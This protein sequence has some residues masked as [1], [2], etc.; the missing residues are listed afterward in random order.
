[1]QRSELGEIGR[2]FEVLGALDE[3]AQAFRA[4]A[5][6]ASLARVLG[7]AGDVDGLEEALSGQQ[8]AERAQRAIEE[9]R[10]AAHHAV[11]TGQRE[12][13]LA[14]LTAVLRTGPNAEL[15]RLRAAIEEAR[16]AR[17]GTR[18]IDARGIARTCVFGDTVVIGRSETAEIP[19]ASPVVSRRH[20]V[21]RAGSD[22]VPRVTIEG[23]GTLLGGALVSGELSVNGHLELLL[24]AVPV[25]LDRDE[26][27]GV[28]VT[29]AG[30]H[31]R[32]WAPLGPLVIGPFVITP[33]GDGLRLVSSSPASHPYLDGS[34]ACPE[35][36]D[37][38]R[39]DRVSA[40]R[41]G[42]SLVTVAR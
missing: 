8:A 41:G 7:A 1:M 30:E 37:L 27:A 38:A 9:A 31:H 22:G 17:R 15:G 16:A 34:T 32:Y 19:V 40:E 10:A 12:A 4:A 21:L 23:R 14:S 42:P 26:G 36:I 11:A 33:T 24:G 29:I 39:G 25:T 2:S 20:L 13:A 5:D 18:L 35:G 6:H 3:A 28:L